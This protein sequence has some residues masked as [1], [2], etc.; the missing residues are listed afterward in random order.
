MGAVQMTVP[1]KQSPRGMS[2]VQLPKSGELVAAQLRRMI[3]RGE[4]VADQALPPESELIQTFG[5]SRP[6]MRES[7][8]ILEAEG[9][10]VVQRGVKGGPRVRVPS[11]DVAARYA[12]FVL[13]HG[14]TTYHDI[15]QAR[16]IL[17]AHCVSMLAKN[18]TQ[19][20][21]AT[22]RLALDDSLTGDNQEAAHAWVEFHNLVV[23]LTGND[24]LV[25]FTRMANTFFETG[26]RNHLTHA[27]EKDPAKHQRLHRS[28]NRVHAKLVD[29]IAARDAVAASDLWLKH[30][31]GAEDV[32]AHDIDLN[33]TFEVLS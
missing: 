2:A 30:V 13:Q 19:D 12:G 17:E 4:L 31:Y 1:A 33:Q 28:A 10:V 9:L 27:A 22:L 16:A 6:T 11:V 24:T 29:L 14:G 3:I 8:R 5:V 21:L 20:Q 25:L 23:E 15:T 18:R 32:M 7:M 26:I